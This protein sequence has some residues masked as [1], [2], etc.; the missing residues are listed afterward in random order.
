V[1]IQQPIISIDRQSKCY[2]VFDC[3]TLLKDFEAYEVEEQAVA[4][5]NAWLGAHTLYEP[6]RV[7]YP[8]IRTIRMS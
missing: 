4:A 6:A 8:K 5:A 7:V 2:A 3:V 1:K